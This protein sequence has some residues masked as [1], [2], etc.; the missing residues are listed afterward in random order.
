M[1]N[2]S[3]ILARLSAFA[4]T[5]VALVCVAPSSIVSAATCQDTGEGCAVGMTGPGGGIIFYDAGSTQWWGRFLEAQTTMTEATVGWGVTSSIGTAGDTRADRLSMAIGMGRYNT[6]LLKTAGSP[7]TRLLTDPTKDWFIPSK[8]E[9]DA[10]YDFWKLNPSGFNYKSA[11][12]WASS[13][14]EDNFFWYQLFQD[15]TQFTDA[16][17]IIPGLKS[18][19]NATTSPKHV[20]SGFDPAPMNIIRVRAFPNGTGFPAGSPLVTATND[21]PSCSLAAVGCRVGDIGPGGGIIVYDAGYDDYWGRYLEVA[22]KSCELTRVAFATTPIGSLFTAS[23]RVRAKAIGAGRL[24]TKTL[25]DRTSTTAA[26]GA[27]KP[28]NG[29]TDWFLP[30]KGE[31]NEA[32]R[33]LSHGRVGT[34]LTPIGQFERGYYWTSSDYNGQTAWTQYFADG[35]QFDRVQTLSGNKSGKANPF[36]VR[37]MRA[38]KSGEIGESAPQAQRAIAIKSAD[39]TTVSGKPGVE[40]IGEAVGFDPGTILKAWVRFPGQPSFTEGTANIRIESDNTFIWTRKTG[41]KT[42]VYIQ[43]PD[44]TKSITSIIPAK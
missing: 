26:Q 36:Y 10:L 12:V 30:S 25:A 4:L 11:P 29:K 8:D 23:D 35:Q 28:C 17:G 22:P 37:P 7:L 18:N 31:L 42:Y 34:A 15:G 14:S 44:G 3:S 5:A 2:S 16:N 6:L 32:F 9:L 40:V 21:N 20:G 1:K 27:R 41:K 19:V 24:N 38:F 43:A 39:R 33:A 13:E